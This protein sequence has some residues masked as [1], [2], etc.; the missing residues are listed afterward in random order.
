MGGDLTPHQGDLIPNGPGYP[1]IVDRNLR[2][3]GGSGPR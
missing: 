1:V 2:N 3:M